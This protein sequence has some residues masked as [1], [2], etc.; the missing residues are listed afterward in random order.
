MPF[1]GHKLLKASVAL[2]ALTQA[3]FTPRDKGRNLVSTELDW[4]A[5]YFKVISEL[6]S[7]EGKPAGMGFRI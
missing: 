5:D 3:A 7:L 1:I 2:M 6:P 4:D